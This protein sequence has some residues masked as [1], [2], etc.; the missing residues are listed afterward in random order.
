MK[1]QLEYKLGDK[2]IFNKFFERKT[3]RKPIG[4]TSFIGRFKQWDIEHLKSPKEGLVIGYRTLSNGYTDFEDGVGT[5]FEQTESFKAMLVVFS[6]FKKP[7]LVPIENFNSTLVESN[8][9]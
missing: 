4:E 5:I 3:T 8:S 9:K 1:K 7:I 2:I 6:M